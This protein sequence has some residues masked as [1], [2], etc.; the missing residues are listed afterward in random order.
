MPPSPQPVQEAAEAD[1][2]AEVVL[3]P[4]HVLALVQEAAE[5]VA[6]RRTVIQKIK[7]EKIY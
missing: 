1:L 6:V 4:V 2:V 7:I 3:A 5:R